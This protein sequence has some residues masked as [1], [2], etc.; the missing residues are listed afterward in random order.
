[1][2]RLEAEANKMKAEMRRSSDPAASIQLRNARQLLKKATKGAKGVAESGRNFRR[3]QSAMTPTPSQPNACEPNLQLNSSEPNLQPNASEL[4][5][6]L[7]ASELNLQPNASIRNSHPD[8]S[9]PIVARM[10]GAIERGVGNS[11]NPS[12][13]SSSDN[14]DDD[15]NSDRDTLTSVLSSKRKERKRATEKEY[16]LVFLYSLGELQRDKKEKKIRIPEPD[17]FD[18]S[19]NG[20]PSHQRWFEKLND[21][22]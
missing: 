17:L 20:N 1:M 9:K 10:R 15:S 13:S 22:L 2:I 7:N 11:S 18:G 14:S 6:Q 3:M 12:S 8:S 21:Y 4:N 16:E 5:W 19:Y